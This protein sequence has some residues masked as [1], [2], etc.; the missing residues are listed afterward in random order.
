MVFQL[1]IGD[2]H[3]FW[4]VDGDL[5]LTDC[6]LIEHLAP[7]HLLH[8][9]RLRLVRTLL[10]PVPSVVKRWPT[11]RRFLGLHEATYVSLKSVHLLEDHLEVES[12][13]QTLHVLL[14]CLRLLTFLAELDPA[15]MPQCEC[16]RILI[17]D[18]QLH[19]LTEGHGLLPIL[20]R[21]SRGFVMLGET[22][23]H[24]VAGVVPLELLE[25]ELADDQEE[26]RH[27][28]HRLHQVDV[29]HQLYL[30]LKYKVG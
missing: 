18:E 9:S 8:L 28:G 7:H 19:L 22:L 26:T 15:D 30:R 27:T 24:L 17:E 25:A 10:P 2:F 3:H 29:R 13:R 14:D 5:L 23:W 20:C 21:L 6:Q 4:F 1:G 12:L 16:D 11:I